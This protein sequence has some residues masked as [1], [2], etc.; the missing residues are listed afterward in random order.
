MATAKRAQT[1]RSCRHQHYQLHEGEEGVL[2]RQADIDVIADLKTKI[3]DLEQT[4][5]QAVEVMSKSQPQ[6]DD[7]PAS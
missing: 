3:E 2:L 6:S 1:N 5:V 7:A 4:L